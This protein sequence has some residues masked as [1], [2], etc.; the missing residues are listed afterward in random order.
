MCAFWQDGRSSQTPAA[1]PPH[2]PAPPCS[3]LAFPFAAAAPSFAEMGNAIGSLIML[4]KGQGQEEEEGD[5]ILLSE[6]HSLILTCCWVSVKV[7][8]SPHGTGRGATQHGTIIQHTPAAASPPLGS[9]I[10]SGD[11]YGGISV[12]TSM[13]SHLSSPPSRKDATARLPKS[14]P[15]PASSQRLTVPCCGSQPTW[16]GALLAPIPPSPPPCQF[17]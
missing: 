16:L 2:C 9:F 14:S 17:C 10:F 12:L 11:E 3:D 8:T 5:S 13:L 6:E 4:G 1:S 15:L 7:G